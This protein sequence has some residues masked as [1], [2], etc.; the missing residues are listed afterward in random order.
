[1]LKILFIGD[2]LG[3]V[4]R[5][6]VRAWLPVLNQKHNLDLIVLNAENLAGGNGINAA[7]IKE[8]EEAGVHVFTGGNHSF[9][10]RE[11]RSLYE[12]L[13]HVLRP[14]NYP[15]RAPGKGAYLATGKRG[16]KILVI[17]VMGRTFIDIA[18][19]CPF[20][21]TDQILE[22][23]KGQTP[24]CFVDFHAE[25]TAEKMCLG[26]HLDGRASVVV[27]SHTHVQTSDERILPLGTGFHTDA[28]L[29]GPYDSVIG[30]KKEAALTRYLT[31]VRSRFE[32]A[33]EDP[34]FCGSLWGLNEETGRCEKV[35]R[36]CFRGFPSPGGMTLK[37]F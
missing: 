32:P 9:D 35:E 34:W 33:T 1:M 3:Q 27:G 7:C 21:A 22:I 17:N 26:W 31:G 2:T 25:A 11:G 24:F 23:H 4:G 13:P 15:N 37:D 8:L 28:G 20:Q 12:T 29:T 10:N 16:H 19:S 14:A 30:M 5:D 18:L 6:M 36:L